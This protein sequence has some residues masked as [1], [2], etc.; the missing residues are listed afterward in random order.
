MVTLSAVKWLVGGAILLSL[1][2]FVNKF[3]R[4]K[5]RAKEDARVIRGHE[6]KDEVM[7][8]IAKN[9]NALDKRVKEIEDADKDGLKHYIDKYI[10][11]HGDG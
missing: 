11:M 3:Y 8:E 6:I 4:M 7:D 10:R 2:Y 1:A 5:A 9:N